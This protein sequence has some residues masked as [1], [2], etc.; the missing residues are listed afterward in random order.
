MAMVEASKLIT[1]EQLLQLPE[2]ESVTR[3]LY[4][5]ELRVRPVTMRR[6]KHFR[7]MVRIGK[8]LDNW[9]D[10]Q[11]GL[12]GIVVCGEVRCRLEKAP[13]TFVGIDV[14]FFPGEDAV[15][16]LEEQSFHDGPPAVAVEIYS[17]SDTHREMIEKAR[18]YLDAGAGQVW[19]AD[20]DLRTI[21]VLRRDEGSQSYDADD[22]LI[23]GDELPGFRV[24]VADLFSRPNQG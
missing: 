20:P 13:D 21:T 4:D 14:A 23:G 15:R 1:T 8:M 3:E 7:A 19:I 6:L 9:L 5:G 2:D 17:D 16:Q 12:V 11:D 22:E 10:E 24:R 18:R